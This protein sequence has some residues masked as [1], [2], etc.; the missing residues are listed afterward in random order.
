MLQST[1]SKA[2]LCAAGG[3][4]AA[5]TALGP[6]AAVS[7]APALP[8][9]GG[10]KVHKGWTTDRTDVHKR[11][12][13]ESRVISYV[14]AHRHIYLKCKVR[15]HGETWYKLA[16]QHGWVNSDTVR[17]RSHVPH[18]RYGWGMNG[19]SMNGSSM[20]DFS[21]YPVEQTAGGMLG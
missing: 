21:T 2:A 11:P 7:A 14:E 10:G 3:A 18:C 15:K 19:S 5:M 12:S 20:N 17:T 4:V 6:A 16:K 13:H 1:L 9:G 8:D